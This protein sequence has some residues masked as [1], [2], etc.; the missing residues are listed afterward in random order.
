MRDLID[1]YE[2]LS[3]GRSVWVNGPPDGVMLARLGP[4][5]YEV[6]PI[7]RSGG[8]PEFAKAVEARYGLVLD[9]K[10]RPVSA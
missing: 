8:W 7:V 6:G 1:G 2:I 10:H 3:D 5:G 9:D 4:H